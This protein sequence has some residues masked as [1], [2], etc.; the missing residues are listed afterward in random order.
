[1][2]MRR[3]RRARVVIDY[4]IVNGSQ[5]PFGGGTDPAINVGA[6]GGNVKYNIKQYVI[7]KVKGLPPKL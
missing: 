4:R 1:M 6:F 5:V 7:S 3:E 2:G